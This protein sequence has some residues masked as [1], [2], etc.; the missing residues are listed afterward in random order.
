VAQPALGTVSLAAGRVLARF[1]VTADAVAGHSYGELTA[2]CAAEVFTTTDLYQLSR[3]RGELMAGEGGDRG[4]MVAVSAPLEQVEK[5]MSE[6][7]LDLVLANKNTPE[8]AVLSGASAEIARAVT[9]LKQHGFS[10]KQLEVSA[11]FHS[12]LIADA[13]QPFAQKLTEI[14]FK[15]PR[16]DVYSNTTGTIYPTAAAA[17]RE[18]LSGQLA[19]PVDFVSEIKNSLNI[20]YI[21]LYICTIKVWIIMVS[22]RIS[23]L[24]QKVL[25]K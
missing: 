2:L 17:V 7:S 25:L 22:L 5:F 14:A 24:L 11:A 10:Y 15:D 4:S 6:N 1:G 20:E 13:A 8:Q 12:P 18:V 9:L 23:T 3:L 19:S 21:V 16:K